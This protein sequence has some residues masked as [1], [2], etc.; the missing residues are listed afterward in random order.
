MSRFAVP[1]ERRKFVVRDI[2]H[3]VDLGYPQKL[4]HVGR[5]MDQRKLA[6]ASANR[7]MSANQFTEAGAVQKLQ[8][9]QIQQNPNLACVQQ[10]AD[11]FA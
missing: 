5:G 1:A 6:A 4:E 2:E 3:L 7:D 10:R 8:P 11:R 9:L